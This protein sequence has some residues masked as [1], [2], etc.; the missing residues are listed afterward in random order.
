M[1]FLL[2]L[3]YLLTLSGIIKATVLSTVFFLVGLEPYIMA[4]GIILFTVY[5]YRIKGEKGGF[6]RLDFYIIMMF[7]FL[8]I[9]LFLIYYL[10]Q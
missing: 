9:I 7:I 4:A 3:P 8:T 5:T 1:I 2:A 6:T 10:Y